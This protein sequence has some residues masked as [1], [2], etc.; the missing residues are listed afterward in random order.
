MSIVIG[1]DK[2]YMYNSLN[3]TIKIHFMSLI[4]IFK[5]KKDQFKYV[6]FKCPLFK[7]SGFKT[8]S[9][10]YAHYFCNHKNNYKKT[11]QTGGSFY[12]N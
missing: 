4:H 3:K 11:I 12:Q 5:F 10:D 2:Y 1:Y 8:S 9:T 6:F 7:L